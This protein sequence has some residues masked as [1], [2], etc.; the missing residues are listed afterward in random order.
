MVYTEF[1]INIFLK[2]RKIWEGVLEWN[3]L[4]ASFSV[5]FGP[6]VLLTLGHRW[7]QPALSLPQSKHLT[8]TAAESASAHLVTGGWPPL[9]G[10]AEAT[11]ESQGVFGASTLTWVV[12]RLSERGVTVGAFMPHVTLALCR[13]CC[14]SPPP[15]THFWLYFHFLNLFLIEI[16]I[17][18]LV[19]FIPLAPPSPSESHTPTPLSSNDLFFFDC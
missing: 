13:L 10:V 18:F 9:L 12:Y 15:H 5:L 7:L 19:L 3:L 1:K 17:S 14:L 4:S 6:G 2:E 11:A 8:P 16:I